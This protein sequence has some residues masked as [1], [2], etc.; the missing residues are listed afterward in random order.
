MRSSPPVLALVAAGALALGAA[1]GFGARELVAGFGGSAE[2]TA[3]AVADPAAAGG[4]PDEALLAELVDAATRLADAV[5]GLERRAVL[6][7][8]PASRRLALPAGAAAGEAPD[9]AAPRDPASEAGLV[10]ALERL[11]RALESG[12]GP[13]GA[14]P[15]HLDV[16]AWSDRTRLNPDPLRRAALS[17]E[18]LAFERAMTDLNL[19]HVGWTAQEL[20]DAYGRPDR[21]D[22]DGTTSCWSY[23]L[24][25]DEA[26]DEYEFFLLEGAV[27]RV[28][29]NCNC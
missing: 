23:R 24:V 21:I 14:A 2:R 9:P 12:A 5:E 15:E 17:L 28:E 8:P 22:W 3:P 19:R 25:R 16:P 7:P 10:A 20:L 13:G 27:V 11:A 29:Y 6:E 4:A 18:D 26:E 1:A